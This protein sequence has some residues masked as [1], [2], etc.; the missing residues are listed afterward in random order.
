MTLRQAQELLKEAS[1]V[2][3]SN[4]NNAEEVLS[5]AKLVI[6]LQTIESRDFVGK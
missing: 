5:Y 2:Y 4:R 3:I 6:E 1:L